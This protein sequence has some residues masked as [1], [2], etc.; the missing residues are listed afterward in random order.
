MNYAAMDP[1]TQYGIGHGCDEDCP[2]LQDGDC[3]VPEDVIKSLPDWD[4]RF[5]LYKRYNLIDIDDLVERRQLID[6]VDIIY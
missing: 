6:I 5:E 4:E 1:C 3:A 2:V